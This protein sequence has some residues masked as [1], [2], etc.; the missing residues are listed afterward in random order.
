MYSRNQRLE[1]VQLYIESGHRCRHVIRQLGYPQSPVSL[2]SW[3][4]DYLEERQS[5]T[6]I[7][8]DSRKSKYTELQKHRAVDHYL[9]NG[10]CYAQTIKSP[11]YP[12]KESLIKWIDELAP[13]QRILHT[14]VA[15][16]TSFDFGQKTDAVINLCHRRDESASV[17]AEKSGV[18]RQTLYKWKTHML[19]EERRGVMEEKAKANQQDR[20]ID[21]GEINKLKDEAM[22]LQEQIDRLQMERDILER[23][24]DL[25]KKDPGADPADLSNREKTILIGALRHKYTL[26]ALLSSLELAKSSYFY[27]VTALESADKYGDLKQRIYELFH[28]N[29]QR[30]GYR[31][32]HAL[33]RLEGIVVSEKVVR[34]AMN[35]L[36]L[37]VMKRNAKRFYS[38]VGEVS[39]A[40]PNLIKRDFHADIPNEKWLTDITEFAIPAGKVYLSPM[41]D[42]FDGLLVSW[43]IG[44]RPD[45]KLANSM[46]RAAITTL[47]NDEKPTVHSDCGSHYRWPG[48]IQIM[49]NAGLVRS[50]SKR[51]CTPDNAACEGLFGRVKN[52]FFYGRDWSE[53]TVEE[54]IDQLSDYLRWYNEVRIKESLNWMSPMQYRQNLGLVA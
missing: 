13:G 10:K 41:L 30:Y 1:A 22:T 44:T 2:R 47:G 20:G 37:M 53:V 51:G 33:L 24:V 3:Y 46:L 11:G 29:C 35:K 19:G 34:A 15:N 52:E 49:D 14:K 12:H 4:G 45:S 26:T 32:I 40:P 18:S 54:F 9:R 8:G 7:F 43:S 25:I 31:R 16:D 6:I 17:I 42:C 27:Q 23:T 39:D 48:W 5:G 21:D 28:S 50:M 38:Y 36:G